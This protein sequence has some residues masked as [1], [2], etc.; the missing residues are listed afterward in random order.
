MNGLW[1]HFQTDLRERHVPT[2]PTEVED[3][4]ILQW[5][6]QQWRNQMWTAL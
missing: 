5:L 2:S 1:L 6:I 3:M 4:L